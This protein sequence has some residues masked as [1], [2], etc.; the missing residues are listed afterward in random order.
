MENSNSR[1]VADESLKVMEEEGKLSLDAI[2]LTIRERMARKMVYELLQPQ[3]AKQTK[4]NLANT[5]SIS[6]LWKLYTN[7]GY[8]LQAIDADIEQLRHT[9]LNEI[10][11]V[12]KEYSLLQEKYNQVKGKN[13]QL[14]EKND[15]LQAEVDYMKKYIPSL[16]DLRT[17]LEEVLEQSDED[18]FDKR[19]TAQSGEDAILAYAIKMLGYKWSD[20]TYLDLGANHAKTLSNTYYFYKNGAKGVLVEA[21]PELIPELRLFRSRDIILNKCIT[22]ESRENVDFYIFNGDGLSTTNKENAEEMLKQ[23]SQLRIKKVVSVSTISLEK[24]LQTYFTEGP[25][26]MN[27]DIE[28]E[29]LN[30]LNGLDFQK[31]RPMFII[32][33]MIPYRPRLVVGEKNQEIELFLNGKGYKEYAFTGINSIFIDYEKIKEMFE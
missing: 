24:I 5:E 6:E 14:Q 27:I 33:E 9:F 25:T 2:Q 30:I 23:N 8:Q 32:I 1:N 19:T 22:K 31:F 11:Q 15:Q 28:G 12:R 10:D 17:Q 4:Y 29:E 21:N 16:I 18:F 3:F 7:Y 26:I 20:I 13:D